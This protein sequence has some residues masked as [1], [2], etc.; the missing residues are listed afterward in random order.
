MCLC[1]CPCPCPGPG[2]GPGPGPGPGLGM[3]TLWDLLELNLQVAVSCLTR[4]LGIKPGS[5]ER[6]AN[7]LN[8]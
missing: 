3:C 6:A 1:P 7:T 2:S 8:Y 4:V 5:S